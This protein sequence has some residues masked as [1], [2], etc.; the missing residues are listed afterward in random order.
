VPVYEFPSSYGQRRM[1]MLAQMDPGEPVYNITRALWLDGPLDTGVLD[2][3]W[4]TALV[5]HEALR[6]VFRNDSWQPVQVIED[7]LAPRPLPVTS[8]ERLPDE[9]REP[10]A[11]ALIRDLARTP[12]DLATGPLVTAALIRLSPRAHVLAVA[13]HHIVAD[14]WSFRIL[15]GELSA[16]YAAISHGD[17]PAAADPPIQYADFAIWQLEHAR[18]GGYTA[19]E[20]FWC[21]ALA[22]PPPPLPLPNDQPYR[23]H[24]THTADSIDT[25]IDPTL[26]VGLRQLAERLGTTQFAVL[27]AAYAATLHHLTGTDDL[28]IAVPVP[29]RTRA[30][31]GSVVGLFMNHVT[32]RV[33][34]DRDATLTDLVRCVHTTVVRAFAQQELPLAR[35]VELVRPGRDPARAPLVQVLFAMEECWTIPDRGGLHWHPEPVANGTATFEIELTVT[36]TPADPRIRLNYNSDLFQPA[37]AQLIADGY[38]TILRQFAEDPGQSIAGTGIMSPTWSARS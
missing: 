30:E 17:S 23:A 19:A 28:L 24:Q 36:D 1:W 38:T 20:R 6:T 18:G 16:D 8:L 12:F 33:Q 4:Q 3:A 29:A 25:G 34:V 5:R 27:L 32:I 9:Q 22:S 31:S 37:T 13:V 26:A 14:G 7:D 11:R 10:A 2:R 15:F 35:V 21:Q